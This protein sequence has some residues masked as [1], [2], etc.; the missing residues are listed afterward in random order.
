[1]KTILQV[2]EEIAPEW[3]I[4]DATDLVVGRLAVKL[5][6][7][8]MGKHRPDYTA[9]VNSGDF[10]VVT[11]VEKIKFTGRKWAQKTY[12][13]YTGYSSG[14][15]TLTAEQIREKNPALILEYA[16]KRM[17]PKNKLA[18]KMISRLKVYAGEDHPH[19][20]QQ[21]KPLKLDI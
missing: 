13:R 15:K 7:M 9:H 1:M 8:L 4:I 3:W 20:A 10:I 6:P 12:D 16:V 5:A 21:P 2:Q 17:L 19:A 18:S 11:N 14:L